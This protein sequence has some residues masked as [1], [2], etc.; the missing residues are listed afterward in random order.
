MR[1]AAGHC[2][3]TTEG[4]AGDCARGSLGSLGDRIDWSS[5]NSPGRPRE[6]RRSALASA[7]LRLC[8]GCT[9]CA[10]V[11]FSL[12]YLDC[13]WYAQCDRLSEEPADFFTISSNAAAPLAPPSA[14]LQ[15]VLD[16]R[17]VCFERRAPMRQMALEVERQRA[18]M[19]RAL[20]RRSV[21]LRPERILWLSTINVNNFAESM[22]MLFRGSRRRTCSPTPRGGPCTQGR[23]ATGTTT[24]GCRRRARHASCSCSCSSHT[25][26]ATGGRSPPPTAFTTTIRPPNT[27]ARRQRSVA[28]QARR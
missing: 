14:A 21:E 2:G 1:L 16:E 4:D 15:A 7:C 19:E 12:R 13:S 27:A 8:N 25:C 23:R 22:L 9:R 18:M 24:R 26:G 3:A 20:A 28:T 11:S 10:H 6:E 17:R 5:I